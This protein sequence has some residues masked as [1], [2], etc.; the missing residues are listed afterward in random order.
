[1]CDIFVKQGGNRGSPFTNPH[2]CGGKKVPVFANRQLSGQLFTFE[3]TLFCV[4][5]IKLYFFQKFFSPNFP[6]FLGKM[7]VFFQIGLEI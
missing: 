4:A 3:Q 7:R 5:K 2:L 6:L 1:M